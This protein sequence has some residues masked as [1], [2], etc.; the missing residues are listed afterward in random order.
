MPLKNG[1]FW[2]TFLRPRPHPGF[3]LLDPVDQQ[4]GIA[5]RDESRIWPAERRPHESTSLAVRPSIF[6]LEVPHILVRVPSSPA[7]KISRTPDPAALYHGHP[8]H[9][10][11]ICFRMPRAPRPPRQTP[12]PSP[13]PR[14]LRFFPL[15]PEKLS[16]SR[17]APSMS[18]EWKARIPRV[19]FRRAR[20]R[21]LSRAH[22][23]ARR[24]RSG[25]GYEFAATTM[26]LASSAALRRLSGS[27]PIRA[28]IPPGCSL[29][30]SFI[31]RSLSPRA[32]TVSETEA[33]RAWAAAYS[34][35]SGRQHVGLSPASRNR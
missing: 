12:H 31:R 2:V 22:P 19:T 8:P 30:A 20:A 15:Y 33:P 34:R 6:S 25:A 28:T 5:V 23:S 21:S 29:D 24:R 9:G 3:E 7:S 27:A 11:S 10:E 4:E 18:G 35:A 16:I 13:R 32:N 26:P 14:Y 1:S 17:V